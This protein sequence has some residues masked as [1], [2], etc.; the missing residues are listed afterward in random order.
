M[1][2]IKKL[3]QGKGSDVF[4]IAPD[5]TVY[6]A[7]KRM[8]DENVGALVVT[9]SAKMVGLI[10]ERT[11]AREVVLKGRT[12]PGTAVRDVMETDV[13]YA[14]P[15]QSVEECMAVMTKMRVRHLPVIDRGQLVGLVSIG[16]LVKSIISQHEFTIAQLVHY[17]QH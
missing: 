2:T 14:K 5:A 4:T 6:E 1:T 16:D 3:L 11:Y 12:S 7:I 8:A 15:E 13:P 10:T 17:I 9:D